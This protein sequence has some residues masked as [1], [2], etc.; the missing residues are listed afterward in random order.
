MTGT[1][2]LHEGDNRSTLRRLIAEG[3]R[4]HAV[5]TDPPYGL[6]SIQKRFGKTDAA[7]AKAEGNDGSF[8]RLSGGFMGK[9]WDATGIERD[10][11]FWRLIFDILLPGGFVFAFSGSRT[12]HWQACAMEMAGF[13]MHPFH[14]WVY[15]SGFPKAH[16][17]GKAVGKLLGEEYRGEWDGWKTGT[18]SQK[19]AIEPIYLGQRPVSEKTYAKNVVLHGVGGVNIDACR[20]PTEDNLNGGAYAEKPSE[21]GELWGESAGN[22]WKRGG[23]GEYTKPAGRYPANL[24]LEDSDVV[25]S[26]FPDSKGQ[27]GDVKGTEQSHIGD[28]GSNCYN[29]YGRIATSKRGDSGSAARFFNAFDPSDILPVFYHKKAGKEDRAGSKHPT[30]KPIGLIQHLVRHITPPG[31]VVLDPFAGSGTTAE[32]ALREGFDCILMEADKQYCADLNARFFSEKVKISNCAS[33]GDELDIPLGVKGVANEQPTCDLLAPSITAD[34]EDGGTCN[35][36]RKDPLAELLGIA[37]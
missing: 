16:D 30:V 32:A 15:G 6:T 33:L 29:T 23:A 37:V 24:L 18:Q 25:K 7:P 2:T 21:R 28:A 3:V 4:V 8:S 13:V 14:G 20:V 36:P 1:V 17:L 10:P 19:P 5:V 35:P 22:S 12:G 27:Q 26:L 11:E 31:G 34:T 9:S